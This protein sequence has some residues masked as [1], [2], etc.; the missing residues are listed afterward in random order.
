MRCIDILLS[1][2]GPSE[3]I[4]A[5]IDGEDIKDASFHYADW[6]FHCVVEMDQDQ[7]DTFSTRGLT[8]FILPLLDH[9]GGQ[10]NA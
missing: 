5:I 8:D 4:R 6:F 7:Q 9:Y 3:W 1:W 2:G 10:G